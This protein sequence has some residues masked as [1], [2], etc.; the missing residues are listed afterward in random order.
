MARLHESICL[1]FFVTAQG[2]TQLGAALASSLS[3]GTVA[4]IVRRGN[5]RMLLWLDVI[6]I[7]ANSILEPERLLLCTKEDLGN[8]HARCTPDW[9]PV[10]FMMA[11]SLDLPTIKGLAKEPATLRVLRV[12]LQT[13]CKAFVDLLHVT[14]VLE[15][16]G[17]SG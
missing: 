10:Y 4:R 9:L 16:V 17:C 13:I 12:I 15:Y 5:D 11:D 1:F 2:A 8:V 7:I 6:N 3:R 14:L